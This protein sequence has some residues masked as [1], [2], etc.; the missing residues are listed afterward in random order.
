MGKIF[1]SVGGNVGIGM[2]KDMVPLV[3]FAFAFAFIDPQ[4]KLYW[5]YIA[6]CNGQIN[7]PATPIS[8]TMRDVDGGH[9]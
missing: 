3:A 2:P 1:F 9:E 4:L 6:S 8:T 7:K 5:Y